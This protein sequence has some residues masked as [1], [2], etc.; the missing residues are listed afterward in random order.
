MA[1][2]APLAVFTQ[3]EE[4][5]VTADIDADWSP[6]S[7]LKKLRY[8]KQMGDA[9]HWNESYMRTLASLPALTEVV[10]PTNLSS[11]F[12]L[13]Q[14]KKM[15]IWNDGH[16]V[17]VLD[18][19]CDVDVTELKVTGPVDCASLVRCFPNLKALVYSDIPADG[20]VDPLPLDE[21]A[22]LE[23]LK[24]ITCSSKNLSFLIGMV[25]M[26]HLSVG[27]IDDL[28]MLRNMKKLRSLR[29]QV[30]T[31]EDV[32]VLVELPELRVLD[33]D[34]TRVRHVACLRGHPRQMDVHLPDEADDQE[35]MVDGKYAL[36]NLKVLRLG[37]K[38]VWPPP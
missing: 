25:N 35:L 22:Q 14:V 17:L 8:L 19:G 10:E 7:N 9:S 21:L 20:R 36:P 33:L 12:P 2:L 16:D 24:L 11:A 31:V 1:S 4:L 38:V 29:L 30:S 13:P 3:L 32:A 5:S 23:R 28:S 18:E 15:T 34:G 37:W 26:V 27:P 6:V